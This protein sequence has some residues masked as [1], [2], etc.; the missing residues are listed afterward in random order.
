[1]TTQPRRLVPIYTTSGDLG[2]YLVYP[3]IYN[4]AGEWVG[5][6]TS[7]REV[8]S[9]LGNYIGWLN[10]DPRI[11]RKRTYDFSKPRK[12]SPMTQPRIRVPATVPL[13]PMMAE[14]SFTVID[15]L[16]DEPERLRTADFDEL[17][18]DMD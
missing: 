7:E 11:L 1:M 9:A 15:V 8:Y 3:Y 6:V 14:L 10:D 5:W 4:P 17:R 13:P 16:E 18:E 2:A 12:A